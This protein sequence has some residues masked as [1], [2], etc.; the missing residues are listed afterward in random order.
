VSGLTSVIVLYVVTILAEGRDDGLQN[1][2]IVWPIAVGVLTIFSLFLFLNGYEFCLRQKRNR[3]RETLRGSFDMYLWRGDTYSVEEH[4]D[5]ERSR[6]LWISY[7]FLT[8]ALFCIMI[9]SVEQYFSLDSS[10]YSNLKHSVDDILL[11]Y[12]V[13]AYMSVAVISLLACIICLLFIFVLI[14]LREIL[15]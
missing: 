12:E 13:L 1:C 4:V 14:Y 15:R 8:F 11:G 5:Y 2:V 6:C 3:R 7:L 10:C 9:V